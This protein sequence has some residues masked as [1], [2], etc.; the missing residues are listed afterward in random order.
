MT[1]ATLYLMAL[2]RLTSRVPR[3]A[4]KRHLASSSVAPVYA[5]A[6]S[7][8]HFCVIPNAKAYRFSRPVQTT[9]SE[10]ER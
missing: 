10:G 6:S 3:G 4:A 5:S 9:C 1:I 8:T 2:P 7:H